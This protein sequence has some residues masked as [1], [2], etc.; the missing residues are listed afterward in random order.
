M[1][2]EDPHQCAPRETMW[3]QGSSRRQRNKDQ[4]KEGGTAYKEV[5][6]EEEDKD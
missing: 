6:A 3:Q 2:M 5:E 1:L 4:V